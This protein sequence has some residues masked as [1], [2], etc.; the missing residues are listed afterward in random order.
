M[1]RARLGGFA[2]DFWVF[3]DLDKIAGPTE[4]IVSDAR[5]ASRAL[6]DG[7][8]AFFVDGDAEELSRAKQNFF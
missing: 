7:Q 5:S 6:R 4:Q 2:I 3:L 1:S 8:S